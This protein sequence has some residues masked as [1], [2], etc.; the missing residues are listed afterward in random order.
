M[1]SKFILHTSRIGI[2][3]SFI[4]FVL[5]ILLIARECKKFDSKTSSGHTKKRLLYRNYF[6]PYPIR[7]PICYHSP[8]IIS[9]V[10]EYNLN[11]HH[12]GFYCSSLFLDHLQY[13]SLCY[14]C[15]HSDNIVDVV[16]V[17]RHNYY[18][19]L[20]NYSSFPNLRRW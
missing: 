4:T 16:Y 13:R 2:V 9:R 19:I 10:Y 6:I 3:I 20:S 14:Q 1:T 18:Y 12:M 17:H 7:F 5:Q 8:S 11:T 15:C